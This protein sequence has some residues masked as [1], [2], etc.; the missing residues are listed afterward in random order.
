MISKALKKMMIWGVIQEEIG[1]PMIFSEEIDRILKKILE[2]ED[3]ENYDDTQYV[4]LV[5]PPGSNPPTQN[6]VKKMNI[7]GC[8]LI[9][10]N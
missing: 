9:S 6:P 10:M 7:I 2:E 3:E 1:V 8:K 4:D 5:Y